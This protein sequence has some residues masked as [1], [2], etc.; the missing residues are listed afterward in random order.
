MI[1]L[2]TVVGLLVVD[3]GNIPDRLQETV[4]IEPPDPLEG[5]EIDA[6]GHYV[7]EPR[8]RR[9]VGARTVQKDLL[10]LRAV[11]R[12]ACEF[13]DE[14]G[15]LLMERDPTRGLAMPKEKNPNRPVA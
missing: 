13:R 5:G 7:P 4:I 14:Q 2:A 11:S 8:K 10:L 6:R 1:L 12:W 3:R 15:R 9:E